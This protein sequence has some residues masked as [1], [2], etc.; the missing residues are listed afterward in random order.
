MGNCCP[1][2]AQDQVVTGTGKTKAFQGEG[3]RLGSVNEAK[4]S[5]GAGQGGYRDE[6]NTDTAPP[7][8]LDPN[9]TDDERAKIRADRAAAAEARLRKQGG[10]TTKTKKPTPND[11]A[12]LTG[13]NST[14]LMRWTAG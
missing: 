4:A 8:A 6:V 12:P 5:G 14:P 9:L 13:P 11:K 10:T 7:A 3:H 1:K 2:S